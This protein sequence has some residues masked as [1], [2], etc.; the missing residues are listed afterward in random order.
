VSIDRAWPGPGIVY[1]SR[2]PVQL[3]K[4]R[5]SKITSTPAYQR[6]TIRNWRTTTTL[7]KMLED[8]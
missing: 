5:M 4:S 2:D 8:G 6:M 3:T 7:G 1:F